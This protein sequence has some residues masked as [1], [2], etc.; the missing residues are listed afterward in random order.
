VREA[1][2]IGKNPYY[3]RGPIRDASHFHDRARET[4]LTLQMVKNKQSVSVTGPRRIGK[5]SFLFHLAGPTVRSKDHFAPECLFV[6]IN[7][8]TLGGLSDSG[9]LRLMLQ[10][11]AAQA[12]GEEVGVS[13]L[14]L[15]DHRLFE[16]AVRELVHHGQHLVYLI[17]EFEYLSGNPNLDAHFFSFL[18][19]L[20]T[21]YSI[22]TASQVSLLT[23]LRGRQLGSHFFNVF[24]PI[25]LGLFSE[26][27]ARQMIRGPSE[28]A[29]I[30][31]GK[32][33][34]DFV[35]DLAGPHPFFLQVACFHAFD[36]S[37][38]CPDLNEL[39]C[40]RL[41]EQ[42]QADLRCHFDYFTS[43][44]SEEEQRALVRLLERGQVEDSIAH[45]DVLERKCLV[46]QRNGAYE[47]VSQAFA[48]FVRQQMD[49]TWSATVEEG[50]RRMTTVLFADVVGFTSMA[51][52]HVP[53]EVL[54]IIKP[55]L[56]MFVEVVDRH[57][58]K[59]AGFGGDSVLAMFGVPTEQ[60]DDAV[61][62]VRAALDILT[63]VA[64]Y[65][66]QL[67]RDRGIDF[68][69]K[70][71][72]DTGVVVLGEIGGE[73]R[74]EFTALGDAVNLAQRIEE[75][76]EPGTVVISGHT[77]QQICRRFDTESLG[78]VE[79]RGRSGPVEAYRVLGEKSSGC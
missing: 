1:K 75:K 64:S 49:I 23:L 5:T 45:L 26:D 60:P 31:F 56:R 76:A 19:S 77:Y 12:G 6:Y 24:V 36:L 18:R 4:A 79:I 13:Q 40:E 52:R 43:R 73:Q 41:E 10:E 62:A 3:H 8:E 20:T 22:V 68:S 44:L 54:T 66:G 32:G 65:A 69:A 71:G 51:E 47:L 2:V 14:E 9:V 33:V 11:T 7:G 53:E 57:G 25:Y 15:V 58:G 16:R 35:L 39:A 67:K 70:V 55:A 61:R 34:E 38:E 29:G 30:K 50:E 37:R 27:D 74:A 21:R 78:Q 17:D 42:V 28:A 48:R 63:S 59:V 46:R 72:L